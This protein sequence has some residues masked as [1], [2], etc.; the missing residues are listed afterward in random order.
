ML[1]LCGS[2]GERLASPAADAK[3]FKAAGVELFLQRLE[4]EWLARQLW[5]MR[6]RLGLGL[7]LELELR[8]EMELEMWL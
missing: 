5:G 8:L 7:K 3:R 2:W 6:M 1:V 4:D